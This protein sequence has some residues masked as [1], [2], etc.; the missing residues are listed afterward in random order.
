MP[1]LPSLDI[2][3]ILEMMLTRLS[4]T[5]NLLYKILQTKA[6]GKVSKLPGPIRKVKLVISHLATTSMAPG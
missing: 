1:V 5:Q 4:F 6:I 2:F 3:S